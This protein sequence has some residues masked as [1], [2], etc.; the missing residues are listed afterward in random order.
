MCQGVMELH[1]LVA[2]SVFI[3]LSLLQFPGGYGVWTWFFFSALCATALHCAA[4]HGTVH[5]TALHCTD[6]V[7][8]ISALQSLTTRWKRKH[9]THLQKISVSWGSSWG[10]V[11]GREGAATKCTILWVCSPGGTSGNWVR[12]HST[13]PAMT[14]RLSWGIRDPCPL[15]L[16]DPWAGMMTGGEPEGMPIPPPMEVRDQHLP[17]TSPTRLLPGSV[18]H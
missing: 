12:G 5:C 18:R 8:C 2:G 9:D 11:R 13:P 4:L 3:C 6:T 17:T 1:G 16:R 14:P 7:H 15:P 10:R